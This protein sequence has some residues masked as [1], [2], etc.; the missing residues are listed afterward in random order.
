MPTTLDD[1]R[2]AKKVFLETWGERLAVNGVGIG[3][4]R[5]GLHL[6]VN[7]QNPPPEKLQVPR[8]ISGV[9]V[10]IRVIGPIERS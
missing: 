1:V 7:L 8:R 3:K 9:R 5:R 6:K 10:S 4:D 2:Q